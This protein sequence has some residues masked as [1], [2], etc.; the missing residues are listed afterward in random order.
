[1]TKIISVEEARKVLVDAGILPESW[2]YTPPVLEI[3]TKLYGYC[4]GFFY[5]NY[6]GVK[7]VVAFG[8]N[9]IVALEEEDGYPNFAYFDEGWVKSRDE[10]IREWKKEPDE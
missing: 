8:S 10:M 6:F 1:M 4:D 5:A 2:Q 7:T 3:G 9:W